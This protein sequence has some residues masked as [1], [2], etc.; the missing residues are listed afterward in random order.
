M[1]ALIVGII[2]ELDST[3]KDVVCSYAESFGLAYQIVDD[4]RDFDGS[5]HGSKVDFEDIR[6]GKLTLPLIKAIELSSP[7]RRN[8]MKLLWEKKNKTLEDVRLLVQWVI[9]TGALIA[10]KKEAVELLDIAWKKLDEFFP[11]SHYKLMIRAL[12]DY[13]L[14][15]YKIQKL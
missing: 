8:E 1:I 9:D 11:D 3:K 15:K 6:E 13:F 10:C 5:F 4:V 7:E 12:S 14:T 2:E